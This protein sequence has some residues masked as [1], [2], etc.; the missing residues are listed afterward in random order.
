[1]TP[2]DDEQNSQTDG[3]MGSCCDDESPEEDDE[4]YNCEE[5]E[6]SEGELSSTEDTSSQQSQ[7]QQQQAHPQPTN[8]KVDVQLKLGSNVTDML[9]NLYNGKP[10][11]E[12]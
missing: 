3:D 5:E 6:E 10:T 11:T 2:E 9:I 8:Q 4:D 12:F 7:P 1:M